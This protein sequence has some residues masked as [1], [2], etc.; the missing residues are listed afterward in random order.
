[1]RI[2]LS[3]QP[4]PETEAFWKAANE[5]RLLLKQC[6]ITGKAFFYPR[7]HSPFTGKAETDWIEACGKGTI[8]AFSV[9]E[10][11]RPA[12]CI[13]YVTL[14]EGPTML[15]SIVCEDFGALRIGQAVELGF[16][17]S[18]NGQLVPIFTPV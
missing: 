15:T 11:A 2:P 9:L 7:D 12:Y 4:T 13:A 18:E 10:R 5:R 6:R 1:M 17:A 3:P 16:I 8:Y 14:E